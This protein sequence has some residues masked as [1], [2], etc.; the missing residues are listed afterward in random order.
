MCGPSE[1]PF[2]WGSKGQKLGVAPENPSSSSRVPEP[3]PAKESSQHQ[4]LLEASKEAD[5][6]AFCHFSFCLFQRRQA[7]GVEIDVLV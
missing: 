4:L 7:S 5:T 1:T 2:M 3:R 6:L